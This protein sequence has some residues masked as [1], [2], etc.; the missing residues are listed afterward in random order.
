MA[1]SLAAIMAEMTGDQWISRA[2]QQNE[3]VLPGEWEEWV[4]WNEGGVTRRIRL[5]QIQPGEE[6][7]EEWHSKSASVC[8]LP[9]G[10]DGCHVPVGE[11]LQRLAKIL[12]P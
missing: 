1:L 10:H 9:R 12:A 5:R 7:C 6:R 8:L 11:A 3:Q 4:T 2:T